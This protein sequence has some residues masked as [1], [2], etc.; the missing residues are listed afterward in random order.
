MAPRLRSCRG[1]HG[2]KGWVLFPGLSGKYSEGVTGGW[3]KVMNIL[4]HGHHSCFLQ[5]HVSR[6]TFATRPFP[7][8]PWSRLWRRPPHYLNTSQRSGRRRRRRNLMAPE[9]FLFC[10]QF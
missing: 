10:K 8:L 5:A 6:E 9:A 7:A 3:E 4:S 1:T 2:T